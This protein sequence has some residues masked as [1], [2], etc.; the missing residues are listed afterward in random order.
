MGYLRIPVAAKNYQPWA[1]FTM[2][3]LCSVNRTSGKSGGHNRKPELPR[4][5]QDALDPI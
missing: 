4:V 2:V 3:F 5:K 1:F